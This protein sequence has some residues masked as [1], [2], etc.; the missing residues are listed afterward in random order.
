MG[1][2]GKKSAPEPSPPPESK[3][4]SVDF[5]IGKKHPER[6]VGDAHQICWKG[7]SVP[8]EEVSSWRLS[9]T[10]TLTNGSLIY[11]LGEMELKT[12]AW[13]VRFSWGGNVGLVGEGAYAQGTYATLREYGRITIAPH[14]AKYLAESV[15]GGNGVIF[16]AD[17]A[18]GDIT[19]NRDGI[20]ALSHYD[21]KGKV[22]IFKEIQHTVPWAD[23]GGCVVTD[24]GVDLLRRDGETS[25]SKIFSHCQRN[26]TNAWALPAL[27][28]GLAP[29]LR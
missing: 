21:E 5:Q 2:F 18:A 1:L 26:Q 9:R 16:G 17:S 29:K 23:Y 3:F 7:E 20:S 19:V 25:E 13:H 12:K 11:C 6:F 24:A 28:D 15:T 27:L 8:L 10:D 4:S 14:V 22:R